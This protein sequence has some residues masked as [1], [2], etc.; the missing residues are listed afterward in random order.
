[1]IFMNNNKLKIKLNKLLDIK[2]N[3]LL[4]YVSHYELSI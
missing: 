2:K 3:I 1:M 4:E